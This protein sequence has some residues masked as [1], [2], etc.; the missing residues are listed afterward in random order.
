MRFTN[1]DGTNELTFEYT[2]KL[3]IMLPTYLKNGGAV[4]FGSTTDGSS[5]KA[6]S[7]A[8]VNL[9]L[10][11]GTMDSDIQVDTTAPNATLSG[12]TYNADN[13]ALVLVGANLTSILATGENSK[14]NIIDRLDWTKIRIDM[15][16]DDPDADTQQVLHQHYIC[17]N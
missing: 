8:A 3:V 17:Q 4:E 13:N 5:V 6:F 11:S 2:I 12:A 10:P 9:D 1:H 16:A 7:G 14:T 15:G